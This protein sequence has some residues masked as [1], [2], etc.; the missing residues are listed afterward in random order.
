MADTV[1]ATLPGVDIVA[2]GEWNLSTGPT[3]F[4]TEDLAAAVDAASCPSIGDP[5]LKLGHVDARFDGEP[6]VGKVK[7]MTLTAGGNKITGDYSGMPAW[8]GEVMA[9][10]YPDRSIEGTYGVVCQQGHTHDFVITAVALLGV[11]APG[12]SVLNSLDDIAALYGVAAMPDANRPGGPWKLLV[13]RGGQMAGTVVAQGITT[14]DV[15]RAY[16]DNP[17][18]SYAMWITELQLDPLQLIVCNESDGSVFRVPIT[19]KAGALEF[20]EPV[21]VSI[22]YVDR[23]ADKPKAGT[24]TY[25]SRDESRKGI[26]IAADNNGWVAR[27][28]KWVYDPDGD[29]DDD[30]TPG[31][32]TDNSHFGTDDKLK[33][34]VTIPPKPKG[35]PPA[36]AAPEAPEA[37][38]SDAHGTPTGDHSHE[39]PAYGTQGSDETHSHSHSHA[40]DDNHA[41]AHAAAETKDGGTDVE[42]TDAQ[43]ASLRA[44][45]GLAEDDTELDGDA[46]L[47]AVAGLRTRADAEP[48]A[49]AVKLPGNTLVVSKEAWEGL[50][51][52][53]EAGERFRKGQEINQRDA[54]IEEAIRAGKFSVAGRD[55]WRRLW[56]VDPEG[57]RAVIAKLQKNVIPVDD[58]GSP[59]GDDGDLMDEEYRSLFPPGA[60]QRAQ[61]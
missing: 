34:G 42:L 19:A 20:G 44:S 55:Q 38:S 6:A 15:R 26:V 23:P 33:P 28:G 13:I 9:S 24:L 53:V 30:G 10:A 46:L 31:G 49:A 11:Q 12:V 18:T 54:V 59:G 58:I 39:H 1:L 25:A 52:R 47:A 37:A 50:Q 16:Y 8:L 29:G 4:T 40:G 48:V 41:H 45:L 35:D 56:D 3:T 14:E 51:K 61:G 2:T 60:T 43:L 7:N 36:A 27:D 17:D 21:P 32:D 22:E 5:K 57:T